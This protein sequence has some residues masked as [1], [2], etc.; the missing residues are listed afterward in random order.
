[1]T[2]RQFAV[3]AAAAALSLVAAVAIYT[4][5]APWTSGSA[6]A[7]KLLPGLEADLPNVTRIVIQQGGTEAVI[8]GAGD[9]WQI[10][11]TDGYPASNE[12]VRTFLNALASAEMIEE[13]TAL[14]DRYSALDVE[15]P[16]KGNAARLVRLED[17]DGKSLAE[18][19]VGKTRFGQ[20]AVAV[21]G[22]YVRRPGDAQSWL[23]D[24]RI[25]GDT[26][27]REW[28]A[29]RVF[30]VP[31]ETVARA[32]IEIPGDKPYTIKRDDSHK[33]HALE[34][35]PEGKKIR[36]VNVV[37]NIIEAASFLDLENVRKAT[38][39]KGGEA[40]TA[41][42]ELDNGLK[43]AMSIRREKDG[44]WLKLD[45]TGEGEAK[46]AADDIMSRAKGWEFQVQPV[47]VA[48]M[49]KKLDELVEDEVDESQAP[50]GQVPGGIPGMPQGIPGLQ[51]LPGMPGAGGGPPPGA[52][53]GP[54]AM[55][56]GAPAQGA[57]PPQP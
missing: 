51:G 36:Y 28:A 5:S 33:A 56:P 24:K 6:N 53:P 44:A 30:E 27:L 40:G 1:M 31:T 22:T 2:P 4:A 11:S 37:N 10:K 50:E 8:E 32:V 12:K 41:T 14:P 29:P 18:I 23:V 3:L 47:K 20:T 26:S 21:A 17:K 19:I 52:T 38:D 39:A 13:K 45:A 49:L 35:I 48:T 16:G 54:G 55:P 15:D 25:V 43:L 46:E 42:L 57:P 34:T 9:A 7:G